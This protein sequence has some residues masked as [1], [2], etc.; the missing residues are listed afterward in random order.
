[1]S[2]ALAAQASFESPPRIRLATPNEG[3]TVHRRTI[4]VQGSFT[5]AP[6]AGPSPRVAAKVD[7]RPMDI[8]VNG[9]VSYDF[10]GSVSL[11]KGLNTVTVEVDDGDGGVSSKSVK[12][13]YAPIPPTK[14]QCATDR[15]GD[16]H[17]RLT[18]MDIVRACARRRGGRVVFSVTTAR[19]PPPIHDG[20]GNPAAP[21]IEIARGEGGH[22]PSA[23]QSCGDAQL[24]GYTVHRWPTVP[25][26]ISGR[27]STW[28]VPLRYL[29][30]RSFQWR[31]YL[32]E[33]D[34]YTD[35]APD[36]GFLAFVVR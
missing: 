33:A 8:S 19:P 15:R 35:T 31:G 12:V 6:V 1:M 20:F 18:H 9:R 32:S 2:A 10:D 27:V 30:K 13:R 5:V 14:G 34:R 36:K 24:R 3:E 17:D 16:S 26:H 23:I 25:F 29:P 4:P 7:G 11:R 22:G 21:C 28:K